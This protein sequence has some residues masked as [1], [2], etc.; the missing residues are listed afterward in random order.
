MFSQ[1]VFLA[2]SLGEMG[3]WNPS[4]SI[5]ECFRNEFYEAAARRRGGESWVQGLEEGC[6]PR[7]QQGAEKLLP[8]QLCE[9][10]WGSW[11]GQQ[12]PPLGTRVSCRTDAR[13]KRTGA[14]QISDGCG[15]NMPLLLSQRR[16][17]EAK[18]RWEWGGVMWG[19]WDKS[20][21]SPAEDEG[22]YGQS[23]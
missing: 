10:R 14:A 13:G 8:R 17:R 23:F 19:E 18:Q 21:F 11:V 9:G 2:K 5:G 3:A 16:W 12:V 20:T 7:E 4:F 15:P 6:C 22:K 1:A